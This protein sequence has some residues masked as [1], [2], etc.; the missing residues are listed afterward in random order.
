M[1]RSATLLISY[2][3]DII[4]VAQY[5]LGEGDVCESGCTAQPQCIE[6]HFVWIGFCAVE[7]QGD[8]LGTILMKVSLGGVI[9]SAHKH[10]LHCEEFSVHS[11]F[12]VELH[13]LRSQL[14]SK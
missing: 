9:G 1:E 13:R 11:K 6:R 7:V 8:F 4:I 2:I 10:A 5:S 3:D 14:A 12:I